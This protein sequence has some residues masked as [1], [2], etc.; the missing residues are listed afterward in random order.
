MPL[1]DAGA[2]ASFTAFVRDRS[3]RMHDVAWLVT[4]NS[5]DARDAV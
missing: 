4:R 5:D 1:A 3:D 2:H